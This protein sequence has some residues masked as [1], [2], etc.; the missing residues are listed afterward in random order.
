MLTHEG[1]SAFLASAK[2]RRLSPRTIEWYAM[3]LNRFAHRFNQLPT[4][5]EPVEV[6]LGEVNGS[7]ETRRGYYRGLRAFYRFLE[8][9][10][11]V[12]NPMAVISPPPARRK[13]PRSLSIVELGWMLAV[14][15]SRRDR[16]LVSLLIDTGIRIG[17]ALSLSPADIG[18]QTIRVSG[19]TGER[20]V[21]VSSLVLEQ[22]RGLGDGRHVFLGHKGPL[23]RSGG[24]S[25]VRQAMKKAG[26]EG[27]KSGPHTLRHTLGRQY[28]SAG[29]DLVSLQRIL[30][31]SSIQTTRIYAEMAMDDITRQHH[32]FTPLKTA[33]LASQMRSFEEVAV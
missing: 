3:I 26:I 16:T 10:H 5:A 28:I 23:T 31:H 2:A 1:V 14:P 24:Y 27:R 15:L 17:E 30:G 4:R 33:L 12:R 21:P 6:F 20:E 7:A 8:K 9:R 32:R 11:R 19:K 22:L 18:E 13:L 25:I 29:G